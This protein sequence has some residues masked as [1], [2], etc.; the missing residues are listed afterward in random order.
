M[1]KHSEQIQVP[2][3]SQQYWI[4]IFIS[5]LALTISAVTLWLTQFRK[6]QIKATKPT[7]IFFGPDG[8]P[9]RNPKIYVRTLLYSTSQKG[10]VVEN[11]YVNLS[12]GQTNQ[13]FSIWVHGETSKLVRGSGLFVNQNGVAAGHHFLVPPDASNFE[14]GAGEYRVE[15]YA[16]IVNQNSPRLLFSTNLNI[17]KQEAEA[18]K[19]KETGVYFDWGPHTN[20]YHT[21]IEKRPER[22]PSLSEIVKHLAS[23]LDQK[24]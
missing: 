22:D 15:I 18:L 3:S 21:L 2:Y 8:G 19:D 1:L 5:V 7:Q 9:E 6:G 16:K 14:F 23:N 4:S 11:M 10:L 24:K 13:S 12:R 17:D 20:R